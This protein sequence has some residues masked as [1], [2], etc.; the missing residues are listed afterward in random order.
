MVK[1]FTW[2]LR[3]KA[4][5][6]RLRVRNGAVRIGEFVLKVP[7]Q[8]GFPYAQIVEAADILQ[9]SFKNGAHA[10]TCWLPDLYNSLLVFFTK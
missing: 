1:S 10:L 5:L 8:R 2:H 9:I 4:L 6:S 3:K 7:C